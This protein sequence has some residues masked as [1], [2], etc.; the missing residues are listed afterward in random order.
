MAFFGDE[1]MK[2]S[3][4]I[5]GVFMIFLLLVNQLMTSCQVKQLASILQMDPLL[6][7]QMT[8]SASTDF[9]KRFRQ[10]M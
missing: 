9:Y 1:N 8:S 10:L 7:N 3:L 4:G 5:E 6:G 2:K